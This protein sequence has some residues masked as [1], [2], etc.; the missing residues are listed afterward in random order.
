MQPPKNFPSAWYALFSLALVTLV[1]TG[2]STSAEVAVSANDGAAEDGASALNNAPAADVAV[3]SAENLDVSQDAPEDVA[4]APVVQ[5]QT[6]SV[7]SDAASAPEP[8]STYVDGTYSATGTYTSPA[9]KEELPVTLTL[10][11]DVIVAASVTTPATHPLSQKF[12][13]IF[14]ENFQQLVV[15]KRLDEVNLTKVSGSSLAPIGFTHAVTQIKAE[16]HS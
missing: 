9:G 8:E 3:A 15:G 5:I 16:A 10:E 7:N 14:A 13:T 4:D 2:C 6:S 1:G 12:Q 11:N